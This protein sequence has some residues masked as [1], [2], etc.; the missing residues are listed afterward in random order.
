MTP[1]SVPRRR[2]EV[3]RL[4]RATRAREVEVEG[5]DA[6][7]RHLSGRARR[8]S[9]PRR[10]TA[11]MSTE[12]DGARRAAWEEHVRRAGAVLFE[13]LRA[14]ATRAAVDEDEA[15]D[16]VEDAKRRVYKYYI[17]V[18]EEVVSRLRT[19]RATRGTT[20]GGRTPKPMVVGVSAPQGCGKTTLT[21]TIVD[22]IRETPKKFLD[23]SAANEMGNVTA[24]TLSVDD[25][26]LTYE[27]QT[28]LGDAHADNDML[29][30]RGNAGTH[31]L[32]L[33]TKTIEA[34]GRINDEDGEMSVVMVP[35]YNKLAKGGRGDR[36]PREEWE[37]VSAPLD[38]LLLEGWLLGFEPIEEE[39]A[40]AINPNLVSVNEALKKYK[41]AIWGPER[42]AWWIIFKVNDPKWVYD[43]R[44]E[45]ERNA[46]GG[47][48]EEQVKDFVDRFMPAYEAYLPGLY[49]NPPP[50]SL[51]VVV[52]KYREVLMVHLSGTDTDQMQM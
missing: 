33:G 43:W 32:D 46:G 12:S 31:E 49:D 4:E 45:A 37:R 41:H 2:V 5:V 40:L 13:R 39:R 24:M 42:V 8:A 15:M 10:V 6:R 47:L 34:L 14:E 19:H 3:F 28:A 7:E 35:R 22:L 36:K 23:E 16:L 25:F 52:D 1:R 30:Y 17:P 29:R 27:E 26:Y 11:V 38:V 9:T 18:Y 44:L 20:P 51:V 48:S 50:E 21:R